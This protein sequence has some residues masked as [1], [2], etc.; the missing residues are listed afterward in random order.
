[1]LKRMM[2]R[3]KTPLSYQLSEYDCGP[4]TVLNALSYL[5]DRKEI[6]PDLIKLIHM[7]CMDGFNVSGE[8]GKTGTSYMAMNFIGNWLNQYRVMRKLPICC[9]PLKSEEIRIDPASRIVTCLQR[10]GCAVARVD[11]SG[12]H[13]VLLTG[14]EEEKICLFDPYFRGNPPQRKGIEMVAGAPDR[15]NR[16]VSWEILNSP[17]KRHYA[18]GDPAKRECIL[19]YNQSGYQQPAAADMYYI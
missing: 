6:A 7:Y 15:M 14:V 11:L 3:V 8:I 17:N 12:G 18:L 9:E 4:T 19:M 2:N 10:G 5:F 1:M 13:Y 16:K